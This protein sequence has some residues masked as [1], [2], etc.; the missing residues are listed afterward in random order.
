MTCPHGGDPFACIPCRAKTMLGAWRL[1]AESRS[2]ARLG[3][4]GSS[5]VGWAQ[6][7]CELLAVVAGEWPTTATP[8]SFDA[9]VT[10]VTGAPLEAVEGYLYRFCGHGR[11][12]VLNCGVCEQSL[13]AAF[14]A[15][16]VHVEMNEIDE[17]RKIAPAP[18]IAAAAN[19]RLVL[20]RMVGV[21]ERAR[22]EATAAGE[23]PMTGGRTTLE[24]TTSA[25]DATCNREATS[26]EGMLERRLE[27]SSSSRARALEDLLHFLASA[28]EESWVS[29]L[30]RPWRTEPPVDAGAPVLHRVLLRDAFLG[31][32]L[33]FVQEL[34]TCGHAHVELIALAD[35]P[36]KDAVWCIDCGAMAVKVAGNVEPFAAT[37]IGA[38]AKALDALVRSGGAVAEAVGDDSAKKK[39]T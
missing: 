1:I 18:E 12:N 10:S 35:L 13:E 16:R 8:A 27:V 6:R 36:H 5:L 9:F 24:R 26:E 4:H 21:P 30:I 3:V 31:D 20:G 11:M 34:A 25:A 15:G 39:R 33:L 28:V 19:E 37:R 2:A 14:A 32:L 23:L 29:P 38:R 17:T 22:G 7:T